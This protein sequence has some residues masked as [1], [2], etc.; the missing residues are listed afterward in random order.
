MYY[1]QTLFYIIFFIIIVT[2]ISKLT[3]IGMNCKQYLCCE[4]F[5]DSITTLDEVFYIIL[6]IYL[7]RCLSEGSQLVTGV[8]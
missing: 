6:I 7:S 8:N 3:F 5:I 2:I 4:C 1:Y